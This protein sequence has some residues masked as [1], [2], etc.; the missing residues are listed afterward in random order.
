[1]QIWLLGTDIDKNLG[2]TVYGQYMQKQTGVAETAQQE[3][4]GSKKIIAGT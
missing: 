3:K 2:C 4:G 1:M